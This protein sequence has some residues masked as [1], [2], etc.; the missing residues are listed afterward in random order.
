MTD[1][2]WDDFPDHDEI[3]LPDLGGDFVTPAER[4]AT[5]A[6]MARD[7][8]TQGLTRAEIAYAL[9]VDEPTVDRLL[10]AGGAQ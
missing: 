3:E 4:A 10:P 5:W 8:Q 7:Y 1:M 6:Q 2:P 9:C